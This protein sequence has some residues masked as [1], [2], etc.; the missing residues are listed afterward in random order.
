MIKARELRFV[1]ALDDYETAVH[2]YRDVFGLEVLMDLDGQGGRGVILQVPTATLELVDV[3]HERMVDE[4]EV[5]RRLDGR[6]RLAVQ[7]DELAEAA[8]AVVDAG[9]EAL[10]DP[11]RTSWG[12]R[13]QRFLTGD[14][15]QLT[16]FQPPDAAEPMSSAIPRSLPY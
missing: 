1:F 13:N 12:D 3:A 16:L 8:R 10:A 5:G 6:V 15:M 14:G 9:A 4:I 2:L 11:V 7:V